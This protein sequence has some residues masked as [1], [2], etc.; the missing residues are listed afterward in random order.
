VER[1]GGYIE[2][3]GDDADGIWWNWSINLRALGQVWDRGCPKNG[4]TVTPTKNG[5]FDVG[6]MI[7]R[8][9]RHTSPSSNLIVCYGKWPSLIGIWY[10]YIEDIYT[11]AIFHSNLLH[12][13]PGIRNGGPSPHFGCYT[14]QLFLVIFRL[15]YLFT[16][17]YLEFR[18]RN[19]FLP[20]TEP[21]FWTWWSNKDVFCFL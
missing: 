5:H 18:A 2:N 14:P 21:F 17:R 10:I 11:W 6:K 19:W 4:I 13:L 15:P 3:T 16:G 1:P 8:G 20:I 9:S 12:Y 7:Q